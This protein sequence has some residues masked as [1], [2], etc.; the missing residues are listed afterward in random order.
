[1]CIY[2]NRCINNSNSQTLKCLQI[3]LH[4]NETGKEGWRDKNK[5][6]LWYKL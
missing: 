5:E 2:I 6:S 4:G 3:L 1:M